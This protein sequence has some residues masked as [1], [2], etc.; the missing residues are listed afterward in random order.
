MIGPK[1]EQTQRP[2]AAEEQLAYELV[3]LR[4]LG[5]CVK[6]RRVHPV[7]GVNRDHRKNRS[8]G[9]L[10]LASNL[11]LLCGSGTDGCHGWVTEHPREAVAEG[12]AVPGWPLADPREWPARRW[13]KVPGR[14]TLSLVWVLYDDVGGFTQITEK[15]ARKRMHEMGWDG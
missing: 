5:V 1:Y 9:G 4:D 7:F 13:V 8:Q 6:C 14:F 12:W 15:E 11:N 10:T 3:T 2:S